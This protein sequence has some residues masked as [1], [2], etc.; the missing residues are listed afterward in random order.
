MKRFVCRAVDKLLSS[1]QL[2]FFISSGRLLAGHKADNPYHEG[3]VEQIWN[4]VKESLSVKHRLVA[5]LLLH[6]WPAFKGGQNRNVPHSEGSSTLTMQPESQAG[7]AN[8]KLL[9]EE[10]QLVIGFT[11]YPLLRG[12]V[13]AVTHQILTIPFC[14]HPG[15]VASCQLSDK[16]A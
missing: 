10:R 4:W 14:T 16:K 12:S 15:R 2:L 8:P 11:P 13:H 1:M 5:S 9:K 6:R 7:H 3:G